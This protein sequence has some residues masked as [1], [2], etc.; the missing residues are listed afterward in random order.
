MA[1]GAIGGAIGTAIAGPVGTVIGGMLGDM[2]GRALAS[3]PFMR[4]ITERLGK[5]AEDTIKWIGTAWENIKRGFGVVTQF[6]TRDIPGLFNRGFV[7][8]TR[9]IPE[10]LLKF[11]QDLGKSMLDSVSNFNLG[12]VLRNTWEGIKNFV[13]GNNNRGGRYQGVNY[14]GPTLSKEAMMS[15]GNP[16][17]VNDREFVIPR[18]GFPILA[19]AV[20]NKLSLQE[21]ERSS[22]QISATFNVAISVNGGLG[23][24]NVEELRGPVLEIIE[25]AWKMATSGTVERGTTVI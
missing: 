21:K 14:F 13:S 19:D 24:N 8:L 7:L 18:D 15:G 17:V 4:P 11:G 6:F 2:A 12:D 22:A 3:M 5:F 10:K 23:T 16:R 25:D 20:S 1:G 9:E